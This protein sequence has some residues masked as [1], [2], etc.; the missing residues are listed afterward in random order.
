MR[1]NKSKNQGR[2]TMSVVHPNAAAPPVGVE[3]AE[4]YPRDEGSGRRLFGGKLPRKKHG[5]WVVA[6]V[7]VVTPS[8][9]PV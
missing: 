6:H 7:R 1:R 8:G 5:P 4:V 9:D 2:G 3:T